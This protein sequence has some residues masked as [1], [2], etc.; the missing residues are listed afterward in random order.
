MIIL[1]LRVNMNM[2]RAPKLVSREV[3]TC[4]VCSTKSLTLEVYYYK[5]PLVNEVMITVGR[6][7]T[8]GYRY[9]DIELLTY[10]KPKRYVLR[11]EGP[12]DLNAL[13]VKS[14]KAIVKIPELGIEIYPGPMAYGY[15][16]TV[17]GVLERVLDVFPTECGEVC[18]G[19]RR[20]I[21]EAM[22]G[23]RKFTLVLEDP[24]GK[25][26]IVHK[27]KGRVIVEELPKATQP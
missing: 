2:D 20:E 16:T 10:S 19:R 5:I 22:E 13:V 11:V 18:E 26:A 9:T 7:G 27:E 1:Y 4:P 12:D 25:S 14:S 21:E 8:C 24:Q 6:C 3:S 17:D 15:I 23:K